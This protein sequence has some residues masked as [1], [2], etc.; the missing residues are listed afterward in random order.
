MFGVEPTPRANTPRSAYTAP[1]MRSNEMLC[2][3][4]SFARSPCLAQRLGG[5]R[6]CTSTHAAGDALAASASSSPQKLIPRRAARISSRLVVWT[7]ELICVMW[8]RIEKQA[9]RALVFLV[10]A[11]AL[12]VL[13]IALE[14]VGRAGHANVVPVAPARGVEPG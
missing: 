2:M 7:C 11:H 13:V 9:A 3:L 8:T 10:S 14:I 12:V 1:R 4:W 5:H 6:T